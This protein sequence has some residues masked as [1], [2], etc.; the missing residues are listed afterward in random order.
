MGAEKN[1]RTAFGLSAVLQ[2]FGWGY[3]GE[4]PQMRGDQSP[5]RGKVRVCIVEHTNY[6]LSSILTDNGYGLE[7]CGAVGECDL[8]GDTGGLWVERRGIFHGTTFKILF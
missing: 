6:H 1:G 4:Y 8:T 3:P 7:K 2:I 5:V